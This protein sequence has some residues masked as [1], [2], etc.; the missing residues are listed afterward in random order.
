MKIVSFQKKQFY[1]HEL[2][3]LNFLTTNASEKNYSKLTF[4]AYIEKVSSI[5]SPSWKV[6]V[7]RE[8]DW[9]KNSIQKVRLIQFSAKWEESS[10]KEDMRLKKQ[11]AEKTVM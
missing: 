5:S 11:H 7:P 2:K 9:A 3:F 4:Y 6:G 1:L 10:M 8:K